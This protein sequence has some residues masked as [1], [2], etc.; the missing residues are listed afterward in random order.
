MIGIIQNNWACADQPYQ[1][2][3]I[4]GSVA[5]ARVKT[6]VLTRARRVGR[7]NR[8]Q[9]REDGTQASRTLRSFGRANMGNLS[10][11]FHECDYLVVRTV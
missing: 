1:L 11:Y 10:T 8:R 2:N 7:W 9:G 5:I 3:K 6:L 4:I